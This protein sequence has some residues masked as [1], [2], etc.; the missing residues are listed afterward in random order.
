MMDR[1]SLRQIAQIFLR[2]GNVNFGSGAVATVLLREKICEENRWLN[3]GQF[4]LCYALARVTPGTNLYALFS[5]AAWFLRGWPGAIIALVASS[6]PASI[7]VILLTLLYELMHGH[8]WGDAA[9]SGAVAAVVG[10]IVAGAWLLVRP[11]VL[12]RNWFRTL[13]LMGGAMALSLGFGITPIPIVF[14]AAVIGFFWQ[15]K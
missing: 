3:E 7:V 8:P 14:L 2:T 4:S 13:V 6:V 5:A 9:I 12:S 10:T 11:V 15:E 1:P